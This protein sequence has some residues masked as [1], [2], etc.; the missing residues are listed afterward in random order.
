MAQQPDEWLPAQPHGAIEPLGNELYWVP[1][2]MRLN[3]WLGISRNM[4]IVRSGDELTLLNPIR[5]D[6]DGER[7]LTRLG[8][9]RHLVRLGCFHG[10][11]DAY[12]KQRFNAEFWCQADSRR[13]PRPPSDHILDEGWP[14]PLQDAELR[15]FREIK[16]PECVLLL[17]RGNGMLVTCDSL[18]HYTDW[19]RHTLGARLMMP[20]LGFRKGVQVGP[21]WKKVQTPAGHDIRP[22]FERLLQLDFDALVS[23]HGAPLMQGARAAARRAVDS[24]FDH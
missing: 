18:Q 24:A 12:L 22:D 16:R 17:R 23:A 11:D 20:V 19:S 1:G 3:W 21:L 9:V 2:T 15:V 4:V 10:C 5:L 6:A 14:L 7:A 8:R 13:Y